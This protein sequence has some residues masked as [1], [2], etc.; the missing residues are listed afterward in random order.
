ML[1]SPEVMFITLGVKRNDYA[2]GAG[3]AAE[4]TTREVRLISS[5]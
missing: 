1:P 5:I 4:M 3:K 2:E